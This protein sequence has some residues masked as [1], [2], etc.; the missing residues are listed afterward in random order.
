MLGPGAPSSW[1][2]RSSPAEQG[3]KRDLEPEGR[4]CVDPTHCWVLPVFSWLSCKTPASHPTGVEV[5]E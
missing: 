3:I 2:E 5:C 1:R 4:G